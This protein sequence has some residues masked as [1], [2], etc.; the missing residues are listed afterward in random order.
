MDSAQLSPFL[1]GGTPLGLPL[2][3]HLIP[4]KILG[5]SIGALCSVGLISFH[6]QEG[7]RSRT[8]NTTKVSDALG[9][10]F[11]LK[12]PIIS[13]FLWW[14]L[15][16]IIFSSQ[17]PVL[18]EPQSRKIQN[19]NPCPMTSFVPGS[20]FKLLIAG[21]KFCIH[22]LNRPPKI[23]HLLRWYTEIWRET[24][25]CYRLYF[26]N[27]STD[28][29]YSTGYIYRYSIYKRKTVTYSLSTGNFLLEGLCCRV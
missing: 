1:Q 19:Q 17:I 4:T 24:V 9:G 23:P 28:T 11:D 6:L 12:T 7:T 29:L 25:T 10:T 8:I 13:P 5:T 16:I 15:R 2:T 14:V 20:R 21:Y 27:I 18:P 22:I 3:Q 26:Y